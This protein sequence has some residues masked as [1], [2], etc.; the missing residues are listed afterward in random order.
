MMSHEIRTPLNGV[1]GMT[2]VLA[3]TDLDAEQRGYADTVRS[4]GE[5]LLTIINDILDFSKIEAGRVELDLVDFDVRETVEEVAEQLAGS[6]HDKGL[7]LALDVACDVPRVVHGDPT[8]I[9]QILVNLVGN[10][11][12]F[13]AVGEIVVTVRAERRAD[14]VELRFEVRD[15]GIGV[16]PAD[17]PRLFE[18][19]TQADSSTTRRFGGSGLG[20]AI[21]QRLA[22]RMGGA[23]A[24]TSE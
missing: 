18:S 14:D 7:E 13:T 3:E 19:F 24:A 11:V 16:D 21:S 5:A 15:T 2:N 12:K 20:L 10:A 17:L 23:I 9:R 6:A 1:L 4:A 8:R 22:R